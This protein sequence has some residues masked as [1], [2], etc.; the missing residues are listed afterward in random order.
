M[1]D[2]GYLE[3]LKN[4]DLKRK[5]VPIMIKGIDKE[6]HTITIYTSVAVKDRDGDF[7]DPKE[8]LFVNYDKHKIFLADH[9]YSLYYI[10]GRCIEYGIDEKG[11]WQKLEYFVDYDGERGDLAK[12]AWYLVGKGVGAFSMNKNWM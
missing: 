5:T 10:I 4:M 2:I 6:K 1:K 12:W 9:Y 7:I 11:L 3:Q 8:F